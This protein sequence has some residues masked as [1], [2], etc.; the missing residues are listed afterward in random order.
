MDNESPEHDVIRLKL[1]NRDLCVRYIKE[2]LLRDNIF[3]LNNN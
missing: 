3:A 2:I 1:L